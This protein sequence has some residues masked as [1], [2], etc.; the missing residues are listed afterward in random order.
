MLAAEVMSHH[1]MHPIW[2][3]RGGGGGLLHSAPPQGVSSGMIP[4][5]LVITGHYAK[6]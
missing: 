3:L 1:H 4:P 6:W 2:A 5:T